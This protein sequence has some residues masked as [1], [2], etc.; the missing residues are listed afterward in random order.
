[1]KTVA[2][3]SQKG[4]SGKSTLSLHLAAHHASRGSKTLLLDMDPQGNLVGWAKR[5]GDVPPDVDTAHASQLGKVLEAARADGYDLVV[6]DTAPSADRASLGAVEAADLVL[7]PCRPAQFDLDA[8]MTT[9][10]L[11][12]MVGKPFAVVLNAAPPRSRVTEEAALGLAEAGAP[13]SQATVY[14]RVALQHCLIDGRTAQEFDPGCPAAREI[15]RLYL[16]MM[17][18]LHADTKEAA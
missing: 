2:I 5:R 15:E 12:R 10:K 11:V 6:L 13:V 16:D 8:V 1:M 14:Q 7:I 9:V 17:T 4:G 3:V 18:R